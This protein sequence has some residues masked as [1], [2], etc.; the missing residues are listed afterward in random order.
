[1]AYTTLAEVKTFC[2]VEGAGDDTLLTAIMGA[3]EL[4]VENKTGRVFDAAAATDQTFSRLNLPEE[5]RFHGN[6][7]YFY[8]ETADDVVSI[9]DSPT[10]IH[11]PEDGPPYYAIRLTDGAW[12]YPTVTVNAYW[13]YSKTP[14]ADIELAVWRIC[15]WMY[16]MRDSQSGDLVIT[17][18]GQVLIPEGVPGDIIAL[19]A[20]YRKVICG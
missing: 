16:D 19:L 12:A 8:S 15:K 6:T 5:G 3:A 9:T 14:P 2:N 13:G 11:I 7:L 10:V 17:P 18:E 1:M 4:F 20:P